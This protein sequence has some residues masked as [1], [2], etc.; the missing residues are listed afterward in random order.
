VIFFPSSVIIDAD[1]DRTRLALSATLLALCHCARGPAQADRARESPVPSKQ[2]ASHPT[3][4]QRLPSVMVENSP[5]Q[6]ASEPVQPASEIAASP[7]RDVALI[8]LGAEHSCAL[9]A[10]GE[11]RCWGRNDFGQVGDGTRANRNRPA[12]VPGPPAMEVAL[13]ALHSCARHR[14]GELRCWGLNDVGQLGDG[15]RSNRDRPVIVRGVSGPTQLALGGGAS[16]ALQRGG[17]VMCFGG[18]NMGV[19]GRLPYEYANPTAQPVPGLGPLSLVA[20]GGGQGCGIG[21]DDSVSCWGD[22][23]YGQVGAGATHRSV[24]VSR[25]RHLDGAGVVELALGSAHSCARARNGRVWCW[26]YNHHGQ[27][28]NGSTSDQAYPVHVRGLAPALR[29][30]AGGLKS[31]AIV[32]G[33]RVFCWGAVQDV[34]NASFTTHHDPLP[35]EVPGAQGAVGIAVGGAHA[36]AIMGDG[37]VRCWGLNSAGQLGSGTNQNSDVA[38]LVL[39]EPG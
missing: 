23:G 31:C 14:N 35:A 1:M 33:Q 19:L 21:V 12:S 8:A 18:N 5:S 37:T 24:G 20:L 9:L 25:V 22:S 2:Q 27:V 17:R 39:G 26:G 36:C 32:T 6:I 10:N 13:G 34:P 30:S 29:L 28:G 4:L 15:T 3:L 38:Q 11:V 7:L 16:C